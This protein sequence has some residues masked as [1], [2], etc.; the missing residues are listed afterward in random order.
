[1]GRWIRA[2]VVALV[3]GLLLAAAHSAGAFIYWSNLNSNAISRANN[4]GTG[5]VTD[6]ITVTNGNPFQ[7]SEYAGHIYWAYYGGNTIGRANIDGSGANSTF[8]TVPTGV[9]A[10]A[11][12]AGHIF[13]S[14]GAGIGRANLD[15]TGVKANF[16]TQGAAGKNT[17]ALTVAGNYVYWIFFQSAAGT[18]WR[19]SVNGTG[20]K[21]FINSGGF[22]CDGVEGGGVAVDTAH[23]FWAN[24]N[25]HTIGRANLDGTHANPQF[26]SGLGGTYS[27]C[28]LTLDPTHLYFG[29][30]YPHTVGRANLDGTGVNQTFIP[31]AGAVCGLAADSGRN[32]GGQPSVFAKNVSVTVTAGT[33]SILLHGKFVPVTGSTLVPAG[34]VLDTRT[35][36][37]SLTSST[38]RGSGQTGQFN[39]A[40]FQVLQP[41]S[42]GGLTVLRMLDSTKGCP[43][44][45]AADVAA[46]DGAAA[47]LSAATG[48]TAAANPRVIAT[49]HSK[50][51]HG[52]FQTRGRYSAASVR[53]TIWDTTDRC[54]GTLTAVTQGTVVV[55]DLALR[56][57]IVL[58]AGKSYLARA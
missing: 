16:I 27:P 24:A 19:A 10:V 26:I 12:G 21:S 54:D 15:G 41:R 42:G 57:N 47:A 36:T 5:V 20:A 17:C 50:D 31:N 55:R 51:A 22:A 49:L 38:A 37:I 45:P 58:T 3:F 1:M 30:F 2:G 35:G 9:N 48:S 13:F 34:S 18:V 53:G 23:V 11:G 28:G 29:E 52:R 6:F 46:A 44:P 14:G 56:R 32:P 8:I 4:D 43:P 25:T 40:V 39:G 7:I 33:V